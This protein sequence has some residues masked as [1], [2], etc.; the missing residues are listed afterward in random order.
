MN[1]HALPHIIYDIHWF[2]IPENP[3]KIIGGY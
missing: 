1:S 3:E 2:L